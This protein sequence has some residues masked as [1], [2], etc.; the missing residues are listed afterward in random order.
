MGLDIYAGTL[1]RY[2]T[3]NWK[4]AAQ[5]FAEANGLGFQ[6]IRAQQ[7]E[8]LSIEEVK[9]AVTRWRDN[10][11]NGLELDPVPLWNEDY[12]VTPYYTD[13]PD[14]DA[15]NALLLYISAKYSDRWG[16]TSRFRQT[17]TL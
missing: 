6:M 5:Q 2:Y 8:E 12:D 9:E 14:W 16:A 15:I 10:I 3:H 17:A 1:T 11:I 4:T 13:K 7:Q